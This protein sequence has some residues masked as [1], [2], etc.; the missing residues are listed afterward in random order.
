MNASIFY[1]LTGFTGFSGYFYF[2]KENRS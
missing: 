1:F 2:L